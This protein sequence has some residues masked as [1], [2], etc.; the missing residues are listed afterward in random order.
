MEYQ[1]RDRFSFIRFLGL[2]LEDKI[3][4]AKAVWMYREQLAQAGV[5]E[6]LFEDFDGHL[7]NKSA[8]RWMVRLSTP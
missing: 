1:I 5:I 2:S 4:D 3:P 8:L 6:A 7:E